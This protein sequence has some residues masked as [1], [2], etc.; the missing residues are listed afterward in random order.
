LTFY[1]S[2]SDP[3]NYQPSN[4]SFGLLPSLEPRI[5]NK[6]DRNRALVERALTDIA[7]FAESAATNDSIPSLPPT[8]A[9]T[10]ATR[11]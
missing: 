7:T 8:E 2:H 5:R 1:I 10:E 3:A 6:K 4:I 11:A 9:D